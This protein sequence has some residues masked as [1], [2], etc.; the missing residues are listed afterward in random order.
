MTESHSARRGESFHK[1]PVFSKDCTVLISVK[2]KQDVTARRIIK[3]VRDVCGEDAI[4][5]CIPRNGDS[6]E[7][8]LIDSDCATRL[9]ESN[10]LFDDDPAFVRHI[11]A[12]IKVVSFMH[13]SGL[14]SDE[15]IERKLKQWRL[16]VLGPI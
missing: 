10:L 16:E 13:L 15:E 2:S 4:L 11:S 1:T 9:V 6:Y 5:T 7:V 8:T 14:I 3:A 12:K